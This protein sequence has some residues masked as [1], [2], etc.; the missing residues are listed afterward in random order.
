MSYEPLIWCP[1]PGYHNLY[2]INEL[3]TVKSLHKRSTQ[4]KKYGKTEVQYI[5]TRISKD[6]YRQLRLM[7]DGKASTK[8][9]HRLLAEVF[10]RQPQG[11]NVVNHI[12]GNK[13][14]NQLH[15]LEWVS[16]SENMSHA[17]KL[18]L[19]TFNRKPVF[20]NLRNKAYRSTTEAAIANGIPYHVLRA[21]LNGQRDNPTGLSYSR[22]SGRQRRK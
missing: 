3:G 5:K 9:V 16:H 18:G 1:I 20:D 17:D 8:S 13:L 14:N 2:V 6:G 7:K 15:N 10:I 21:Y 11:R 22:R 19:S 4:A 12:D